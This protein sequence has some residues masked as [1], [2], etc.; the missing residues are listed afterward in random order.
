MEEILGLFL[1]KE[2]LIFQNCV[3]ETSAKDKMARCPEGYTNANLKICQ[4]LCL[5]MKAICWRFHI[6]IPF[7]FWDMPAGDMWKKKK[8]KIT[9]FL[10]ILQTSRA[11]NGQLLELRMRNFHSIVFVWT[12]SYRV[13][14]KSA[15]VYL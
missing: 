10:R 4:Y 7:T 3:K 5:H 6:K 9:Y 2:T 15:L 14:F 11:S 12:Q 13:I 1:A 8:K